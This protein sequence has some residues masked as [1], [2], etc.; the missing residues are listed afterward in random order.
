MSL[1][2]LLASHQPSSARVGGI[3]VQ[4][5]LI[6][7]AVYYD[8]GRNNN[9]THIVIAPAGRTIPDDRANLRLTST[10]DS[11]LFKDADA[12]R[13]SALSGARVE[14]M[15]PEILSLVEE[16]GIDNLVLHCF[17]EDQNSY[18]SA[19]LVAGLVTAFD[20]LRN[21]ERNIEALM[22]RVATVERAVDRERLGDLERQRTSATQEEHAE[23]ERNQIQ[24]GVRSA[25]SDSI[26]EEYL[27]KRVKDMKLDAAFAQAAGNRGELVYDI[28][29]SETNPNYVGPI[30]A[31]MLANAPPA[32]TAEVREQVQNPQR[33]V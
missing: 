1:R 33:L 28:L 10:Y 14:H 31:E 24:R 30:V 25:H 9:V 11:S 17:A 7:D 27:A 13:T 3:T 8:P 15:L 20:A 23:I 16:R 2:Q 18:D 4:T 6:G 21:G 19:R 26:S 12:Q 29:L 5:H 22:K 32:A